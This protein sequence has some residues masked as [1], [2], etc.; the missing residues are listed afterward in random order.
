MSEVKR[1]AVPRYGFRKFAVVLDDVF[2]EEECEELIAITESREYHP[3][4]INVGGGRQVRIEEYEII[5]AVSLIIQILH[6]KCIKG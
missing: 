2:S 5:S 3:A 1:V 4:L 6:K